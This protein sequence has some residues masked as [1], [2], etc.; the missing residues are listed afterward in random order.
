MTT[1]FKYRKFAAFLVAIVTLWPIGA[2]A[3]L[4][5]TTQLSAAERDADPHRWTGIVMS[6]SR[7]SSVPLRRGS[8]SVA[9]HP[10]IVVSC[11]H[12]IH[13]NGAWFI[14]DYRWF[15]KWPKSTIPAASEGKLMRGEIRWASYHE[16]KRNDI[17]SGVPSNESSYN[18]FDFDITA[19]WSFEDTANGSFAGWH[20]DGQGAMKSNRSKMVSGYPARPFDANTFSMFRTGPFT[21]SF[22]EQPKDTRGSSFTTRYMRPGNY[23]TVNLAGNSGG[24]LWVRSDNGAWAQAGVFVSAGAGVTALDSAAW[25]IVVQAITAAGNAP[26]PLPVSDDHPNTAENATVVTPGVARGGVLEAAGDIDFFQFTV[27]T[28]ADYVIQT[29][30]STDTYGSLL[31]A[32]LAVIAETDDGGAGTNFRI[33]RRLSAGRYYVRVRG[34][35]ATTTG[36][37]SLLVAQSAITVPNIGV[38][39][40]SNRP[41]LSGNTSPEAANGTLFGNVI[42]NQSLTRTFTVSNTG[43]GGLALSGNPRVSISGTGASHFTVST[44]PA[45]SVAAGASSQ[46]V[47]GFRPTARGAHRATIS[48]ANSDESKNPYIFA[49]EGIGTDTTTRDDHG[50]NF[51]SATALGSAR[52]RSGRINYGGDEDCFSFSVAQAGLFTIET[53]GTT[54]TYGFLH[55]GARAFLSLDNDSGDRLNFRIVRQ[56]TPG[57]YFVRVRGFG[58]QTVGDYTLEISERREEPEINITTP[59]LT[60]IP[61]GSTAP[62]VET[63]TDFGSVLHAS[64]QVERIFRI[65]NLGFANLLL[66]GE[67]RVV[68]SGAGAAQFQV[69]AQP[70]GVIARGA[71]TALRIRYRPATPGTHTAT[72]TIPNTDSDENPYTFVIRG[73]GSGAADDHGNTPATAT[74]LRFPAGIGQS[75][76]IAGAL[77]RGGDEDVFRFEVPEAQT[78]RVET[79]GNTDTVGRLLDSASR[80]LAQDNNNGTDLNFRIEQLLQPG[81]YY[82]RVLGSSKSIEGSYQLRLVSVQRAPTGLRVLDRSGQHV[83]SGSLGTPGT[84]FGSVAAVNAVRDLSFTL[85][86]RD[87]GAVQLTGAPMVRIFGSDAASFVVI[88][89]PATLIAARNG[90]SPLVVRFDPRRI[91]VHRATV[92]IRSNDETAPFYRFAISGTGTGAEM[93]ADDHGDDRLTATRAT[94]NA[95][96]AGVIGHASDQDWFSFVIPRESMVTMFTTG[97]TDTYGHLHNAVGVQLAFDDNSGSAPNFRIVRKLSAGTY[98]VRVRGFSAATRGNYLLRVESRDAR[99]EITMLNLVTDFGTVVSGRGARALQFRIGNTGEGTLVLEGTQRVSITGEGSSHFAVLAQP[100]ASVL[101]GAATPFTVRFAPMAVGEHTATLNIWSND[102]RNPFTIAI[103][104]SGSSSGGAADDHG[105]ES[106]SATTL[107]LNFTLPGVLERGGDID[108]FRIIIPSNGL[109]SVES[110]G[111]TDTYGTLYDS[112]GQLIAFDDDSAGIGLNF[113][114]MRAVSPG[115]YFL[116]VT[117]YSPTTTGAYS[118]RATLAASTPDDHGDLF[119]TATPFNGIPEKISG[120]LSQG[121]VDVFRFTLPAPASIRTY[122]E[123]TTDTYGELY[124]A[125]GTL[126]AGDDDSGKNF[127]FEIIRLGLPAGTYYI[128]VRGYR[129]TSTGPYILHL[130]EP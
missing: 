57:T 56:L 91:G 8:G 114:I 96:V 5:T 34:S 7:G 119:S 97:S 104:G 79:T 89:E 40:L 50:D 128:R 73:A 124:S 35:A 80:Q 94:V 60:P 33:S 12:N 6:Y 118:V 117:G 121:D 2:D 74:V 51:D 15:W 99:P 28:T 27:A 92:E 102:A 1:S 76:Q 65:E 122:T 123:G 38:S 109:L 10:K 112:S 48:I 87:V 127:N 55:N 45:A 129:S 63:G 75:V 29:S 120:Q 47:I 53:K 81:T 90:T 103:R 108:Y 71:F 111:G 43:N 125:S 30:G 64:G 44:Q 93:T 26:P 52:S 77:E 84:D 21:H 39:G 25:S 13:N 11:A 9:R 78:V 16:A 17:A 20:A 100:A 58:S 68:L 105:N 95:N 4:L 72:V 67:P 107:A 3:Q 32:N 115:T 36:A 70:A 126:L 18:A 88:R 116:R 14:G 23:D 19:F 54:D 42:V 85:Q 22:R 46:F 69:V 41:I 110:S 82:I 113:K 86:N 24:P 31:D 106:T 62:S 98:F 101:P 130:E 49:V 37:Y 66:N 83:P 59:D 61:R